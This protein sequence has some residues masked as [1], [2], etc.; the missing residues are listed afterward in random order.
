MF[1]VSTGMGLDVFSDCFQL[2]GE[3]NS[4]LLNEK[5]PDKFSFRRMLCSLNHYIFFFLIQFITKLKKIF[6]TSQFCV[7]APS[8]IDGIAILAHGWKW[9]TCGWGQGRLGGR[10]LEVKYFKLLWNCILRMQM[11]PSQQYGSGHPHLLG[12]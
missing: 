10:S 11:G 12:N 7:S 3:N 5:T 9:G 2:E 4:F 8:A 1:F 6:L